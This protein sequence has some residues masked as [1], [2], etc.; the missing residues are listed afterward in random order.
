[1]RCRPAW[2][3]RPGSW[4]RPPAEWNRRVGRTARCLMA[5]S[6]GMA[7][8]GR[9]P[10]IIRPTTAMC[11]IPRAD[12]A[13]LRATGSP[14]ATASITTRSPRTLKPRVLSR[15]RATRSAAHAYAACSACSAFSAAL[16]LELAALLGS[17]KAEQHPMAIT[18]STTTGTQLLGFFIEFPSSSSRWNGR[19]RPA[20]PWRHTV[21]TRG[22]ASDAVQATGASWPH[23]QRRHFR[24]CPEPGWRRSA[25]GRTRCA[26]R[27]RHC[28]GRGPPGPPRGGA[29]RRQRGV[30][31]YSIVD[32]PQQRIVRLEVDP[33]LSGLFVGFIEGAQFLA[34]LRRWLGRRDGAGA[35]PAGG[36]ALTTGELAAVQPWL[37]AVSM[38]HDNESALLTFTRRPLGTRA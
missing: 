25:T 32:D 6:A 20:V 2:P 3:R 14:S 1:M 24:V 9:W 10:E 34:D 5:L 17:A 26:R 35:A 28:E 38:M 8:I 15:R 37:A 33:T 12:N 16:I 7:E 29:S 31:H 19:S 13:A 36:S 27:R 30:Y 4:S 18:V 11:C 23:V 22:R 21:D